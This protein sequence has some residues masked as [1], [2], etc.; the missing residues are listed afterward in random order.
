MEPECSY[1][2][3]DSM[4]L[5]SILSQINPVHPSRLGDV[6]VSVL[7]IG[8]KVRGFKPGRG[9]GFL[10][11]IKVR[12]TPSFGGVKASDAC[13]KLLRDVKETVVVWKRYFVS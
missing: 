3:H 4:S 9:D 1:Q 5:V 10:T 2:C 11:A 13:R 6:M 8:P 12:S 7:A